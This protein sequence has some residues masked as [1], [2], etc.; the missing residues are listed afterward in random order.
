[1]EDVVEEVHRRP[2]SQARARGVR[3]GRNTGYQDALGVLVRL[4]QRG[5]VRRDEVEEVIAQNC[6]R[7]GRPVPDGGSMQRRVERL[8]Y[9]FEQT[10]LTI[11][12]T[13]NDGMT[14]SPGWRVSS[15]PRGGAAMPGV[16]AWPS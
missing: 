8:R 6:R 4:L 15:R 2:Q 13:I 1:M 7:E 9:T 14:W 5:Q 12:P 10:G 11:E 3:S 16:S